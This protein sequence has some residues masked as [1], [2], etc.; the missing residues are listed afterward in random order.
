LARGVGVAWILAG[1][2]V[3]R[4]QDR[5]PNNPFDVAH[6]SKAA[7]KQTEQTLAE[8]AD[9]A[10][11]YA[12]PLVLM[13]VTAQA[14][15]N[16][17]T[18]DNQHA[19]PNQF[20][21]MESLPDPA[22][23]AVVLPN[24]DTLYTAAF[25]DLSREPVVLH[26]PDTQGRY[27]LMPMLDAYSNVFAS[28]GKRTTGTAELNVA[29]VGPRFKGQLP[30]GLRK[31]VA[32]TDRVWL[33]GRTQ[34]NGKEDLPK[35]TELTRKYT[36]TP[37]SSYGKPYTPKPNAVD[38]KIDMK[39][40][41]PKIVANL[42]DRAYFER[43]A[44]LLERFPPPAADKPALER[45][46][47]LGFEPGKFTPSPAADKAIQGAGERAVK[48]MRAH[49]VEIGKLQ[50]GWR[51]S[52]AT[53]SYGTRYAERGAVALYAFG[54]NLPEDALY[55]AA[56]RDASGQPLDGKS[57]YVIHFAK[58]QQPPVEAFWSLTMYH[59]SGYLV[60]NPI[61]RYAIGSRDALTPNP[62]GSVDI[63]IQADAP[64]GDRG[65]NW[66]P[67]PS[68]PFQLLMRMYWPTESVISGRWVMPPVERVKP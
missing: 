67:A 42:D 16:V 60:E 40:P 13:D 2:L 61:Q 24:V 28:P 37:L 47:K 56:A 15:I 50:N 34:I 7:E 48:Q 12:Y 51:V 20:A 63:L 62:D 54:A 43:A 58:G 11:V 1:A 32:P 52:M 33:L 36:L 41:P 45:F 49:V 19:P 39:T 29:V 3:A 46:A 65:G 14:M 64:Q 38:P 18:P 6:G 23:N 8:L 21:R 31:I 4:A 27:Y 9:E 30:K 26:V 44:R 35:V 53:G 10:Y 5:I 68:G 66:L 22:F 55:P 59:S 25:L 17:A 57:R